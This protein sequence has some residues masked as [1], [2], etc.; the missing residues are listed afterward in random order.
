M[1]LLRGVRAGRDAGAS[2][3]HYV[4]RAEGRSDVLIEQVR[5]LI[6][7]LGAR[8]S[9]GARR[10]A[11][12][13]DAETLNLPAQNALLKTLE[14]PPGY[15]IIFLV[16][17]SERALLD[18]V[19]SRLRPVRFAPLDVA[20]DR[21]QSLSA[22][23]GLDAERAGALARAGARQRRPRALSWRTA[24]SRRSANCRGARRG[25][26]LDF[27]QAQASGRRNFSPAASRRP[28]ISS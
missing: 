27:A 20:D 23:A 16:A 5:E 21:R 28:R 17:E 10:V 1:R 12:I 9:R 13:D 25:A 15:A 24:P 8:P 4:A 22:R 6:A 14:E 3:L 2:G 19:R 11:I 7:R 26:T 18:T